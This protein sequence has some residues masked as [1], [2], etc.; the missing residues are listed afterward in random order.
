[1]ESI[2]LL[3]NTCFHSLYA[4]PSF[5]SPETVKLLPQ[6]QKDEMKQYCSQAVDASRLS[7]TLDFQAAAAAEGSVHCCGGSAACGNPFVT[8][9]GAPSPP[10][11]AQVFCTG[12]ASC[13]A[14]GE[15]R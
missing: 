12:T 1:M 2:A 9:P 10:G 14:F 5:K 3:E 11:Q 8:E 15:R 13:K 7:H 4:C 6:K